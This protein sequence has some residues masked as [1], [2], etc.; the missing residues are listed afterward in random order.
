MI[1]PEKF[2]EVKLKIVDIWERPWESVA[3]YKDVPRLA[4][5]FHVIGEDGRR[6]D[7]NVDDIPSPRLGRKV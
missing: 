2:Q 5:R 7:P 4:S 6:L 3:A 1:G